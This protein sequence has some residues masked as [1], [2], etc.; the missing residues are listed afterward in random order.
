MPLGKIRLSLNRPVFE[1]YLYLFPLPLYGEQN[2]PAV[3]IKANPWPQYQQ[4]AR[5]IVGER[6]PSSRA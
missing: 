4:A 3:L 6:N 1:S 2:G 5:L